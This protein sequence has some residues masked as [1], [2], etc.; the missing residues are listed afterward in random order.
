MMYS[1]KAVGFLRGIAIRI[2]RFFVRSFFTRGCL[3]TGKKRRDSRGA[4]IFFGKIKI[5]SGNGTKSLDA[6][7]KDNI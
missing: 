6:N 2:G 3:R 1:R 7:K 4:G 5:Y